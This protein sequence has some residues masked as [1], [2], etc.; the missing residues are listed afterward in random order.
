MDLME[1]KAKELFCSY[2]IPATV[3]IVAD[4]AEELIEKCEEIQYPVVIKAQV[5]TGGRGKAG[6]IKFAENKTELRNAAESVFGL[7]IKGHIVKKVMVTDKSDVVKELYLSIL[8]DR[9]TKCPV[10]LFTQM[11]GVDIE[12][13]AKNHPEAIYTVVIDP[14]IGLRDYAARYLASK[15]NLTKEQSEQLNQL[16]KKL[17]AMFQECNCM[18]CEINPLAITT[19]GNLIALDG[20]VS[21]DDSGLKRMPE[22]LAYSKTQ[23]KH[24]LV[25]E[26]ERFNFLFI[27]CDE[28]GDIAV[29]SNGSG[30]IMSCID[31]ISKNKMSVRASLDMGGGATSDRIKEAIR[32]L[33]SDEKIKLLFINIFGGITRCDEVAL[34]IKLAVEKAEI[35]KPIIVRFEGTN[36][37]QGL[38]ILESIDAVT[39]VPGLLE[40]V[41]E[42]VKCERKMQEGKGQ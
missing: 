12:Q 21:I 30:M 24:P 39:Y 10:I 23:V 31:M 32:I 35:Q 1:Y 29:M 13:T 37:N 9:K 16:I 40:G 20:K 5:Q 25:E 33:L 22:L 11:G 7:D 2:G 34:G 19:E 3:G 6:G 28:K 41:M 4:S 15:A 36:K 8:L 14:I 42:L 26:S 17:Y 27:P 38:E 18:L